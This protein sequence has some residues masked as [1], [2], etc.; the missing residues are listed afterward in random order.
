MSSFV[1]LTA[2][3]ISKESDEYFSAL[4]LERNY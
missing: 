2:L 3:D 1:I 4:A